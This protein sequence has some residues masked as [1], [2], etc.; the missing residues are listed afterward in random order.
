MRMCVAQCCTCAMVCGIWQGEDAEPGQCPPV[1][2]PAASRDSVKEELIRTSRTLQ[3][4]HRPAR[5]R[6]VWLREQT[7]QTSS[8]PANISVLTSSWTWDYPARGEACRF[9]LERGAWEDKR[10]SHLLSLQQHSKSIPSGGKRAEDSQTQS[11]SL[12]ISCEPPLWNG[13][14]SDHLD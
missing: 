2:L 7:N 4:P 10:P 1:W 3:P 6:P 14:E 9:R 11:C 13:L 5:N 8:G 12:L